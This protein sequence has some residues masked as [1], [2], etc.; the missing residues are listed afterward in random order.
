MTAPPSTIGTVH[1]V[2][3]LTIEYTDAQGQVQ[4]TE[5]LQGAHFTLRVQSNALQ[6]VHATAATASPTATAAAAVPGVAESSAASSQSWQRI[7]PSVWAMLLFGLFALITAIE[8]WIEHNPDDTA[9]SLVTMSLG[10]IGAIALWAAFWALLGKIFAKHAD[11]WQHVCLVLIAGITLSVLMA[12]MHF[13]SFSLSW[14]ILGRIDNLASVA[15]LALLVWA[16]LRLIVPAQRSKALRIGMIT[17]LLASV[18]LLM[19]TNYRRQDTVLDTFHS[20]HLYRPW[21]QM[22]SPQVSQSFF[23]QAKSLEATLKSKADQTE[24]GE[25]SAGSQED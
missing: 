4:R 9:Q 6:V 25:D 17:F 11:F 13:L 1:T 14:R 23:E 10:L 21:L 19:W 2:N 18:C 8:L 24:A 16:H 12:A 22:S 3:T 20:S 15:A 7:A 5:Q